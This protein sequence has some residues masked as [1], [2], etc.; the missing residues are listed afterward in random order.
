[1]VAGMNVSSSTGCPM[2]FGKVCFERARRGIRLRI[3]GLLT[4]LATA[5]TAIAAVVPAK[6]AEVGFGTYFLG[7][8]GASAGIVPGPGVYFSYDV[9]LYRGD[10]SAN[11]VL[12]Y[13]SVLA[14]GIKADSCC[15][16]YVPTVTWMTPLQVL[17][18]TFGLVA[19][20]PFGRVNV[21][22]A[23]QLSSPLLSSVVATNVHDSSFTVGD[24]YL[25][26]LIGWHS[27]NLHWNAG[28]GF[29]APVGQ[30]NANRL[31][32][33]AYHRTS[34]DPY[35]ALTWF[36]PL[37]GIDL[38]GAIGVT[39]NLRNPD[40]NYRT[41]NELHI[42]WAASKV[43]ANGFSFG[44]IGYHYQQL[45]DDTGTGATLGPFRG[46]VTALGGTVAYNFKI[47]DR[48]ISTRIKVFKEFNVENRLQGTIGVLSLAMPLTAPAK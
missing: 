4:A 18:G 30:Y 11:T 23:A 38:S 36:D 27:G 20:V 37:I 48:D 40:T 33:L 47:A 15:F 12:P 17:G 28:L 21:D 44:L 41:G 8:R 22:A 3:R 46:R 1:M 34:F 24:P 25:T 39:F 10:V 26:A 31:A 13:N 32:N 7:A 35:V 14:A 16:V 29:N 2:C 43:F 42:E 5:T 9:I 6:A 45:T 19:A